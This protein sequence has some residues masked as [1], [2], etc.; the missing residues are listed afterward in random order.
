MNELERFAL[1]TGVAVGVA[2][3][4]GV[5]MFLRERWLQYKSMKEELLR[6]Q[7]EQ[8]LQEDNYKAYMETSD[9]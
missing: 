6:F 8:H 1:G 5:V 4:G 2:F 7:E 3:L 9:E